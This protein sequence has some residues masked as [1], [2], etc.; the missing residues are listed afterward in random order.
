MGPGRYDKWPHPPCRSSA[1]AFSPAQTVSSAAQAATTEFARIAG[2]GE[3]EE[4]YLKPGAFPPSLPGLLGP[5]RELLRFPPLHPSPPPPHRSCTLSR[6]VLR[7]G[8]QGNLHSLEEED[9]SRALSGR[10]LGA[11]RRRVLGLDPLSQPPE[12]LRLQQYTSGQCLSVCL[13]LPPG[14]GGRRGS[15]ASS[16][17]ELPTADGRLLLA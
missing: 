6:A 9:K 15:G 10:G 13:P 3:E 5:G 8:A 7:T 1:S 14:G 12:T 11:P 17:P 16:V 4:D 2:Q